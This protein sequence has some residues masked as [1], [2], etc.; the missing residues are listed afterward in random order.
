M[1]GE[2]APRGGVVARMTKTLPADPAAR[3]HAEL[4]FE[5]GKHVRLRLAADL[6]PAGLL[7]I[8]ALVSGILLS[9][10]VVVSAAGR[11]AAHAPRR[12]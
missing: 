9:T 12:A 7:S 5:A 4:L 6:S 10:A 11:A 8:A 2:P 1:S 3:Q